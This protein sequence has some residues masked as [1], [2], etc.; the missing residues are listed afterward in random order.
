MKVFLRVVGALAALFLVL[1]VPEKDPTVPALT[2]RRASFA[3]NRD[4]FWN[5]L[6]ERFR[7]LRDA[8]CATADSAPA[9]ELAVL[10]A[11]TVRLSAEAVAADA[12]VLDSLETRFLSMGPVAAA[13]PVYARDYVGL[14][15]QIRD[16]IKWQ[17]RQWDVTSDGVRSRLYRALYGTR[18]GAEEV[19]LHHPEGLSPLLAGRNEPSATPAA[20]VHG[21]EIHSG[22]ILI[23][24]G[25]YPTSALIA[26]GNDYPGNFSHIALVHVDSAT[27]RASTIEAHIERGVAIATA[28][29]YLGDKKLR[30]LVLRPR[31][32]LPALIADP[33]LP[34]QAATHALNRAETER[35]PYDFAMDYSDPSRLFCS[36]V[37]SAAYAHFGLNLWMGI[38]TISSPGLRR[39]LRSFGVR[40]FET[41]EPSD[42]EYDPQ[43]VVVAEWREPATLMQDH[44]DNAVIDAMLEGA[45]EGDRLEYPWYQL[46]LVRL[47]KGYSWLVGRFGVVGPVPQGMSA[48]AALRNSAFGKRERRLARLVR[49]QV[50]DARASAGYP[51]PYWRL[52]DL[53]RGAVSGEGDK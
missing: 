9:L 13:C 14:S 48:T 4:G 31:A 19:M 51:P 3:W 30:I 34:H 20:M 32:D 8:G 36:E 41:Q 46:P 21:V 28:A 18:A 39:W 40:H 16:A 2:A 23:S 33:M 44:I 10:H 11:I 42:L 22:D 15:G 1:A 29:E 49:S 27:H 43:L 17:S 50:D 5:A 6:E 52:L 26:R 35:I 24:R 12:P 53:A 45:E 25:G 7:G 47:A 38:S 37:A